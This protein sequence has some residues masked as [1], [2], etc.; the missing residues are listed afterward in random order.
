MA[1]RK[2]RVFTIEPGKM[3]VGIGHH[4]EPG[5]E[6]QDLKTAD[7]MAEIMLNIILPDLPVNK[8]DSVSVL[9]SGLGATPVMEQ[10]ILYNKVSD[11]LADEGVLFLEPLK[12]TAPA[13]DHV[14]VLP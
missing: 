11:I 1:S 8:G 3:E 4:G 2:P 5:V 14:T 7:E 12:P 9:V 10:Y 13:L 6:V